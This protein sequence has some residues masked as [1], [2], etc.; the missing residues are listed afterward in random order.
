MDTHTHTAWL[1]CC[2]VWCSSE[3]VIMFRPTWTFIFS[4]LSVLIFILSLLKWKV[5]V[6]VSCF[7]VLGSSKRNYV[8]SYARCQRSSWGYWWLQYFLCVLHVMWRERLGWW[9]EVAVGGAVVHSRQVRVQSKWILST[10][11]VNVTYF[12]CWWKFGHTQEGRICGCQ[13]LTRFRFFVFIFSGGDWFEFLLVKTHPD[14]CFRDK[15][16]V[17][18]ISAGFFILHIQLR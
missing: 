12:L 14:T 16:S 9:E 3:S 10:H 2:R 6:A 5:Y 18:I 1:T 11:A 13:S 17:N 4:C 8:S 7:S 15:T